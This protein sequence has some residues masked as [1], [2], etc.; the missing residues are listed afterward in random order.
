MPLTRPSYISDDA[1]VYYDSDLNTTITTDANGNLLPLSSP[2]SASFVAS[3]LSVMTS[4]QVNNVDV[5]IPDSCR[6]NDLILL[7]LWTDED[8]LSAPNTPSGYTSVTN[9][10]TGENPRGHLFSKLLDTNDSAG[11]T[12]NVTFSGNDYVSSIVGGFRPGSYPLNI[13]IVDTVGLRGPNALSGSLDGTGGGTPLIYVIGLT[14]RFSTPLQFPVLTWSDADEIIES[15]DG[16]LDLGYKIFNKER[17]AA[18]PGSTSF[19][20]NDGGRQNITGAIIKFE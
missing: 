13:S 11:T 14:G 2:A 3:R 9:Q 10:G 6:A 8:N 19:S 18:I 12:M 5:S 1:K 4:S 20:T 15:A 16:N 7:W 17:G